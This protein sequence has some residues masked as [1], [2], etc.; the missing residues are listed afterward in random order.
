MT[1]LTNYLVTVTGWAALFL[2]IIG[3]WGQLWQAGLGIGAGLLGIVFTEFYFE[4]R[5]R[6]GRWGTLS[7][8]GIAAGVAVLEIA[9][10]LVIAA[11]LQSKL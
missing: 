11:F 4:L 9:Y 2:T 8:L 6:D 5:W 1:K 7:A 3:P 10:I